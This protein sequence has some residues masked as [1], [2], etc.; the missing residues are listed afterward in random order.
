MFD[1]FN[2]AWTLESLLVTTWAF[3]GS[4]QRFGSLASASSVLKSAS[5]FGRFKTCS[6]AE[7]VMRKAL[8]SSRYS[9]A[10]MG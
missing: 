3:S 5:N 4:S 9:R 6:I 8:T 1:L 10:A 7:R 2:V